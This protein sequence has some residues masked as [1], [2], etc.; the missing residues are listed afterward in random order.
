MSDR[1]DKDELESWTI[2]S[3]DRVFRQE[4]KIHQFQ[5]WRLPRPVRL[6]AFGWFAAVLLISFILSR[7]PG[8]KVAYD[9]I[10]PPFRYAVIPI[11][12]AWGATQVNTQG[13]ST[14]KFLASCLHNAVRSGRRSLGRVV[15]DQGRV[16][17]LDWC[18]WVSRDHYVPYLRRATIIGPA[19][20]EFR[21][22]VWA[23]SDRKG[24]TVTVLGLAPSQRPLRKR[25]LHGPGKFNSTRRIEVPDGA[26]MKVLPL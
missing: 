7:F 5:G 15:T 21:D 3:Y 22:R 20:V 8:I 12:A 25:L 2:H 9:V 11:G 14:L 4:R 17:K 13:R 1:N 6:A 24:Q 23:K 16:V 19:K 10:P 18:V 26:T